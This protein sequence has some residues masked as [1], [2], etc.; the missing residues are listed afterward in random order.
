MCDRGWIERHAQDRPQ[1]LAEKSQ[2]GVRRVV[3]AR[4]VERIELRR[5]LWR[6]DIGGCRA[7]SSA[8]P[9][10]LEQFGLESSRV[11][12]RL[13]TPRRQFLDF[14]V[15]Q[16]DAAPLRDAR[17]NLAHDL[18]DV[19][20]VRPLDATGLLESRPL[21][22]LGPAPIGAPAPPVEMAPAPL[23]VIRR[24]GVSTF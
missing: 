14:L 12:D 15:R 24:H 20:T 5:A 13:E 11:E 3:E 19:D 4:L 9:Q 6:R 17:P 21:A 1:Q 16:V 22:P 7:F 10:L 18:L 8:A 23:V 2:Q